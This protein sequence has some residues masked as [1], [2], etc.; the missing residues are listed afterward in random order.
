MEDDKHVAHVRVYIYIVVLSEFT[1]P[2]P[3]KDTPKLS[4]TLL[5]LHT[6]ALAGCCGKSMA[7]AF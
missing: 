1:K 6:A 2:R 4:Q 5:P 7:N 3:K